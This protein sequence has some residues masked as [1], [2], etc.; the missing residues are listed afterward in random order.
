M[1]CKDCGAPIVKTGLAPS[2][3]EHEA[4]LCLSRL[5]G[6]IVRLTRA[7]VVISTGCTGVDTYA[8]AY[9][10]IVLEALS[11][12]LEA[13]THEGRQG[14]LEQANVGLATENARLTERVSHLELEIKQANEEADED[15]TKLV[16]FAQDNV[17]LREVLGPFVAITQRDENDAILI[18]VTPQMVT[19]AKLALTRQDTPGKLP[20]TQSPGSE[21]AAGGTDGLVP[22][23]PP[24]VSTTAQ[25]ADE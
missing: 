25:G 6:R 8:S 16:R 20:L 1:N 18:R 14:E 12:H 10:D 15:E 7:L 9:A 24:A 17:R 19:T 21:Q 2:N 22:I 5:K 13:L 23:Q 3:V 4:P 11:D